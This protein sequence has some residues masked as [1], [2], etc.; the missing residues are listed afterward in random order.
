MK[1]RKAHIMRGGKLSDTCWD[2]ESEAWQA[3]KYFGR[4]FIHCLSWNIG[5]RLYKLWSFWWFLTCIW[6]YCSLSLFK[7]D[8]S[9][10][11][12]FAVGAIEVMGFLLVQNLLKII[13]FNFHFTLSD[14]FILLNFNFMNF[15]CSRAATGNV[16]RTTPVWQDVSSIT[17][18]C[19]QFQSI[20]NGHG[21][22]AAGDLMHTIRV[23]TI[24]QFAI[25]WTVVSF[26]SAD[27][28]LFLNLFALCPWSF[29]C[30]FLLAT[31]FCNLVLST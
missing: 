23:W 7:D 17:D 1:R 19:N 18:G 2:E 24:F 9:S 13:L 12:G 31:N 21:F 15:R 10:Y 3:S 27:V 20:C 4:V 25:V 14:N 22:T 26:L 8:P 28:V 30:V 5:R 29:V 16:N 11:A 6:S